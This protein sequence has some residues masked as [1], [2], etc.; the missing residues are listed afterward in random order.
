MHDAWKSVILD[1]MEVSFQGTYYNE[2]VQMNKK[3]LW[4]K[5][6]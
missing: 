3:Y 4:K 5:H 1:G 6:D 2:E